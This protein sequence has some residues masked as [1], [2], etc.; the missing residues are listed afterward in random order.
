MKN[1]IKYLFFIFPFYMAS[2]SSED[3]YNEDA[4]QEEGEITKIEA[5][6]SSF[7]AEDAESRISISMGNWPNFGD[8]LWAEGDTIGIYPSKGDQ[9]SF[10]IVEGVGT[11]FCEFNGGGWALKTSSSYTAY[12]PFNRNYYQYMKNDALPVSM[13][14]QKQVGNNSSAHVG[15]YDLQ[16]ATGTTPSSGKIS[17]S[18]QHQVSFVRM[19]LTAPNAATWKSVTLESNAA[20]TTNATMNLSSETP[21]LTATAQSN[22]VTLELENVKT[23]ADNLSIVAYMMLL[24]VN[25]TGKTLD[26][27]LTDVDGNVYTA[28]ATIANNKYNFGAASA[29]WIS[30]EFEEST[31]S[32]EIPYVTFS[33]E[34][35]QSLTLAN[36]NIE[37]SVNGGEWKMLGSTTV[38]FGGELG[39]LRLRAKDNYAG[40]G[41][42]PIRFGNVAPV[43]CTGDIRTL[44]D[45][46]EYETV[47]TGSAKFQY[48]FEY[49][50]QL[51]S[52][53]V[54]PAITLAYA[55]YQEMFSGCTSLTSAPVL[56][57]TTLAESCYSRM[58]YGCT[59]LTEAPVLP[60]TTLDS[61][62]YSYMFEGCTSLTEAPVLP[63]TTLDSNCYS[64]MFEG[65]TSLEE[66]PALPA[67][68]LAGYCYGGMF[69]GCTSLKEAPVLPAT[70]LAESCYSRMFYGCTSLTEAPV[71]PATTLDYD[72]YSG[73]FSGCTSLK[74]APVLP[75][76]ALAVYCYGGMFSGC[77]SLKE[78]PALPATALAVYCYSG[79]FQDC[80]SLE[81]A[82]ELPATVLAERCYGSMFQGCTSLEKAPK[83][84]AKG[85]AYGCYSGWSPDYQNNGV[86][87]SSEGGMFSGCTSLKEAPVLPATTLASYCYWGMFSGCTSLEEAPV[88]PAT[89]LASYCY[90]G[91]FSGCTG[92]TSAPELP[93]TTLASYCYSDMFSGCTG[94]EE[95]P[96]LPATTLASSC[97]SGMFQG[98]SNLNKVTMLATDISAYNCLYYWLYNVPYYT[99]TFIKA[100]EMTTLPTG[101][102]GIPYG[103]TVVDYEE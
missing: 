67:T 52:A 65:C 73:M 49:C 24:P 70:T 97:Y 87:W 28:P 22:S 19:D 13:L 2:C 99:G 54:L 46:E 11:K 98:C 56:P 43:A 94:L 32:E 66:A 48:L 45:Y 36:A 6:V 50:S 21:S 80:T 37:Y 95:A 89:T 103:W 27:K 62:C 51:I 20:F 17:F 14:G 81:K 38:W 44:I 84:P 59:S 30:A 57:A 68:A 55:C 63:A 3:L 5:T 60:A 101:S 100:A 86:S 74:E 26:V 58:F 8:V 12:T 25:F 82:P 75:A 31:G 91:M 88:L 53:P 47:Y 18:F 9:V 69:S 96:V 85:L 83:L 7:D 102:S 79:M 72:C 77:T 64:Y 41:S 39:N 40:T 78:A 4:L 10:P 29:R 16:I 42:N 34:T 93:A 1:I 71:L 61:N 15:A 92:L 76:T 23:T 35:Q 33:A 90:S